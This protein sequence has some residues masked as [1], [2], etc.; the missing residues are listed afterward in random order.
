MIPQ[1]FSVDFATKK[2]KIL[3]TTNASAV[4]TFKVAYKLSHSLCPTISAVTSA[5]FSVTFKKTI[6]LA[7]TSP[8]VD[9]PYVLMDPVTFLSWTADSNLGTST[10]DP[11]LCGQLEVTFWSTKSGGTK[12]QVTAATPVFSDNTVTK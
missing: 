5:T 12:T 2:F 10:A 9:T 8:F 1:V 4:G 6:N 7:A 3:Q 11:L